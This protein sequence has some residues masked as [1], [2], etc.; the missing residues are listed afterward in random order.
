MAICPECKS[1]NETAGVL[2]DNDGLFFVEEEALETSGND[3]MMGRYL[4]DR[5]AVMGCLGSGGMGKVY[6]A[7]Q[8]PVGRRVALKVLKTALQ[9]NEK[10]LARFAREAQAI[11]LL[12]HPNI[13]T[14]FDFGTDVDG[15][16]YIAME[17]VEGRP[18][19]L[20]L[21]R[22]IDSS[23]VTHIAVQTLAAL[24]AA[25]EQGITHRDLKPDNIML[26]TVGNDD[27]FV[28]VLDFGLAQLASGDGEDLVIT[29]AGEVF[30]TP[31]YMSPEQATGEEITYA[32]DIYSL[33]CILYEL[34]TGK[35][36]FHGTRPMNVLM[37]HV[38]A[39]VP[40]IEPKP[41]VNP[42]R[43]LKDVVM[44][45]LAKSPLERFKTANEVLAA[46]QQTTEGSTVNLSIPSMSRSLE[47]LQR[48]ALEDT[49]QATRVPGHETNDELTTT[50]EIG[51]SVP[52]N[53]TTGKSPNHSV[54]PR[55][56]AIGRR[57]P[58]R[59]ESS[60]PNKLLFL[61][62]TVLLGLLVLLGFLIFGGSPPSPQ[63]P[64]RDVEITTLAQSNPSLTNLP[65]RTAVSNAV[66]QA[67]LKVRF[68]FLVHN[69]DEALSDPANTKLPRLK[70][71]RSLSDDQWAD[72]ISH[73]H[74]MK[75][76]ARGYVDPIGLL[77]D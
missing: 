6:E 36:P 20:Y 4:G 12:N 57:S 41:G 22:D 70:I 56:P 68:H 15:T 48:E 27:L 62:A 75:V 38:N 8:F 21:K 63:E 18:L 34:L 67:T 65:A 19:T 61:A 24:Q 49:G 42:S 76:S 32:T 72:Q 43:S 71:K 33:G 64:A 25:H 39:P 1:F 44:R 50:D 5:F 13:V 58:V 11:A 47:S 77:F 51:R 31:L 3:P 73:Y 35:P 59:T 74:L 37:K 26:T 45:C 69:F 14:L 54:R 2:C 66:S 10:F 40:P 46:L 16:H 30:G 53:L 7:V 60:P 52:R 28:K 17:Y 29:A 23:L 9:D 55:A